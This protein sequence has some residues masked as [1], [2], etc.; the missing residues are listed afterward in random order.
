MMVTCCN[1]LNY[2]VNLVV[3]IMKAAEYCQSPEL[4]I[5]TIDWG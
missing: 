1:R 3:N 2:Q 4:G 5:L